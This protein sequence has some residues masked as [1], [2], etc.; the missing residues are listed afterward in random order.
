MGKFLDEVEENI[1]YDKWYCWHYPTEKQIDK[2]EFMFQS[3]KLFNEDEY[4][5]ENE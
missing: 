4:L 5:Y 1:N 3:I 2:L